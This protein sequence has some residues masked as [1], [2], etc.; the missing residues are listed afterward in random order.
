M[1]PENI[2]LNYMKFNWDNNSYWLQGS[3]KEFSVTFGDI[4]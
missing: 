1:S 3:L 2:G 4:I